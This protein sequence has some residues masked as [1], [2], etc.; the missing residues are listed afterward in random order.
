MARRIATIRGTAMA[1]GVSLNGR[2]Y[3][4]ELIG[5]AV[6]RAQE[7]LAGGEPLTM[8]TH[9]G[10]E[11]DSTRIVGRV[12]SLTQAADGS[13]R[14]VADLADTA[15]GRDLAALVEGEEPYLD[16]VSI[17]GWWL[18]DVR[19]E[20]H[21]GQMVET[22]DDL[23]LDGLDFTKTP[24][25]LAARVDRDRATA[26]ECTGG[27]VLVYESVAATV[28]PTRTPY[29]DVPYAD[30]G[31]RP[32]KV[33]RLPI[34]TTE[35]AIRAWQRLESGEAASYTA[36]QLKRIRA[37]VKEAL[38]NFGVDVSE[39]TTRY[40]EVT[41]YYPESGGAAGFCVDAWNGPLSITV[42]ACGIEPGDLHTIAAAAMAAG[43][44][45]LAAMDPDMDADIDAA[46]TAEPQVPAVVETAPDTAPAAPAGDT[47]TT[48]QEVPAVSEAQSTAA[49]TAAPTTPAP[50]MVALTQEQFAALLDR[51]AAPAPVAEAAPVEPVV[52]ETAD[53]RVARLVAEQ[54]EGIKDSLRA[55]LRAVGP[56][57][58][59]LVTPTK[60]SQAAPER[61]LH[62]MSEEER[63]AYATK[64]LNGAFGFE[65]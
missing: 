57:R 28:E 39:H 48:T 35:H 50:P 29:G 53:Q 49:E 19:Q 45:A 2:L 31:Y 59:G 38:K 51:V 36:P 47:T 33:R 55:E 12:T 1:P 52:E 43:C 15:H 58:L 44:G 9:H 18:G 32:D 26:T 27:R 16:G 21:R 3:S 61:P 56:R 17:R 6:K 13:A 23:E 8:L 7:R 37:R 10:A 11:D 25:V 40:G 65:V 30:L 64:A 62:E 24:G 5:K 54:V 14:F 20:Q 41:E 42:R 46:E 60:E 4:K 22:G 34:D 63:N